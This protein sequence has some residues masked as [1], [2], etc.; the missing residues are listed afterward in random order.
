MVKELSCRIIFLASPGG[1]ADE[2]VVCRDTI[3]EFHRSDSLKTGATFFAHAWEDVSGGVGRPQDLINPNL[4]ESDFLLVILGDQWGTPPSLDGKYSSGTEEEFT[5]ALELLADPDRP[6]RDILVLF[7]TLDAARLRDPGEKLKPVM[8]F[9]ARLEASKQVM[10]ETFDSAGSLRIAVSNKLREWSQPLQPKRAIKI[11]LPTL[12]ETSLVPSGLQHEELLRAARD[13]A[14]RKLWM[15]AET[16][17]SM[18]I[19]GGNAQAMLEFAKFM[20]RSGRIDRALELNQQVLADRSTLLSTA[21]EA[22]AARVDALANIGVIQRKRGDLLASVNSLHEAVETAGSGQREVAESLNYALD[23]YG[24]TLLALGEAD[25]AIQQFERAH[26]LRLALGEPVAIAQSAINL[27]RHRLSRQDL[28][29]ALAS[30]EDALAR[31]RTSPDDHLLAN[32]LAGAAEVHLLMGDADGAEPLV[33]EALE[34]NEKLQNSDGLSI[35]HALLAHMFIV[36]HDWDGATAEIEKAA[37]ETAKTAN[38]NGRAVIGWLRGELSRGR[39]D[40]SAARTYLLEAEPLARAS[41]NLGLAQRIRE[42]LAA[43]GHTVD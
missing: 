33:I 41:G 1:L 13:F 23:N 38:R 28:D 25:D 36:R 43:L 37:V 2:R 19:A 9:R 24:L 27:G 14:D 16:A 42:A 18:A 32:A 39:G 30:F 29:P 17:Y 5:R 10:Y 40:A 15:Q 4:D 22:V 26:E 34:L 31:L 7:K 11:V 20:R 21:P 35:S 12:E 6:M 3:D 8:D